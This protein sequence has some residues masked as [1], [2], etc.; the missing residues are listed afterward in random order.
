MKFGEQ[1]PMTLS[2]LHKPTH[3]KLHVTIL[4]QKHGWIDTTDVARKG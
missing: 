3:A 2:W 4:E 1:S